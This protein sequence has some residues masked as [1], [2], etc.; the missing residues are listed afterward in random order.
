MG[1]TYLDDRQIRQLVITREAPNQK[2]DAQDLQG[3]T[4]QS[5]NLENISFKGSNLSQAN[6]KGANLKNACLIGTNLNLTD[7]QDAYLFGAVMK[8][9]QLDGSDLTGSCLTAATIED[10]N[11]TLTTKLQG[12]RC[13]YVYMRIPTETKRNPL[14][15]PDDENRNFEPGEFEEFIKPMVD[16]L[17]LYHR[18]NADPKAAIISL[19]Q[20]REGNPNAELNLQSIER[21]KSR[22][23]TD[24]GYC[25]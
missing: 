16:T 20:L 23:F 25:E 5:A 9:A 15:K 12:I 19:N 3:I 6:L 17:D 22:W 13:E 4:L 1:F 7:L 18:Q 8:Q 21:I 14:R 2:F 11:I 24:P 10:W